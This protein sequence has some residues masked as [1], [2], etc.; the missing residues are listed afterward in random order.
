VAGAPTQT[1]KTVFSLGAYAGVGPNLN[2]TNAA[3]SRQLAGPFTTVSINV[4]IGVANLGVQ[5][6]FGGGIWQFSVT[7]P[8]VSAGIGAAGSV[9]TT[10]TVA[11]QTGCHN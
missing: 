9:V 11:T 7:P 2:F 1:A 4:G 3:S 8:I 6:S 5:L 10:N